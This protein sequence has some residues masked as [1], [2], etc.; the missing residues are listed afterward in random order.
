MKP[1]GRRTKS[2]ESRR[3]ARDSSL[4]EDI[5]ERARTKD[6]ERGIRVLSRT[7]LRTAGSQPDNRYSRMPLTILI[8]EGFSRGLIESV[9]LRG[10]LSNLLAD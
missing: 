1:P 9:L 10:D 5:R 8:L 4:Y 7:R 2:R 3:Q 6:A